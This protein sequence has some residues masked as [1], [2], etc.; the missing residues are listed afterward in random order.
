MTSSMIDL[1]P[2]RTRPSPPPA[3]TMRPPSRRGYWAAAIVAVLG[4][5]VAVIWGALGSIRALDQVDEFDRTAIPGAVMVSVTDPGT[6]VVY[7]ES[8]AQHA[9]YADPTASGRPA[10][11]W[12]PAT[13]ATIEARY[14]ATTP[15]WQQLQ[16]QVT[17]PNGAAV[18]VSTYRSGVRYDVDPGR[19]GRAVATFQATIVGQYQVSAMRA[20]EAGATLAVGG[21]LRQDHRHHHLGRSRP[22]AG[23]GAGGGAAGHRHLPGTVT[24]H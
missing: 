19:L 18:P 24:D 22:R 6:M 2:L 12:N 20:T 10:T 23:D 9:G 16:L 14:A 8:L 5:S 11:R 15:T 1:R 13:D 4:L 17:A 3:P 21:Q 7:Y